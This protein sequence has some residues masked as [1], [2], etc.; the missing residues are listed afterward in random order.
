LLIARALEEG[1]LDGPVARLLARAWQAPAARS[2]VRRLDLPPDVRVV[3]VGGATLGGSGKTPLAVACARA[4]A[5]AGARTVLVGH[6]YRAKPRRARI[7]SCE[8]SLADVGDEALVAARALAPH[9]VDVVVAPRRADAIAWAARHAD[10]LVVDGVL[11]TAPVRAALALLAVDA[12]EPW[13]ATGSVPPRGDLRAPIAALLR[14]ADRVVALGDAETGDDPPDAQV[15][16][17]G[18]WLGGSLVG[19]E[20]IARLRVGLACA[21]ARPARLLRFLDRR[22]VRP[23]VVARSGDHRAIALEAMRAPSRTQPLDLWLATPKCVLHA[24]F[25]AAA[26]AVERRTGSAP[27]ATID[28]DVVLS[29]ALGARLRMLARERSRTQTRL[30]RLAAP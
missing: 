4:V 24:P 20:E 2:V 14:A 6:A 10:V 28:H 27:L 26:P 9:R 15:V 23:I 22:G 18:A 25:P 19:W 3:A 17:R 12:E 16:S 7:V 8:D 11:Q 5:S 13:G 21:L 1:L 30:E 29:P